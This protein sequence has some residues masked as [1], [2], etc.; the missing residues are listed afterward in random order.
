LKIYDF[1]FLERIPLLLNKFFVGINENVYYEDGWLKKLEN[2]LSF[3]F[4]FDF[5]F[6]TT[7]PVLL[8]II[9]IEE[10]HPFFFG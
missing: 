2:G 4:C 3:C 5:W 6:H 9:R 7:L 8:E 1:D 10:W